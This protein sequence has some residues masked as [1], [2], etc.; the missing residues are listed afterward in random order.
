MA[1][2]DHTN[3]VLVYPRGWGVIF[4]ALHPFD[5]D[6]GISPWSGV[7]CWLSFM[8]SLDGAPLLAGVAKPWMAV[9]SEVVDS[10]GCWG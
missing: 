9:N 8:I 5:V 1:G 7:L 10:Q 4:S 6:D 3:S 2:V